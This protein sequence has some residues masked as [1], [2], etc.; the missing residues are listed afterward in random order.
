[1]NFMQEH[2]FSGS[3]YILRPQSENIIFRAQFFKRGALK[4]ILL[5]FF[6]GGGGEQLIQRGAF[7]KKVLFE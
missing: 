5:S 1:M 2:C 3:E 7:L 4:N 6:L